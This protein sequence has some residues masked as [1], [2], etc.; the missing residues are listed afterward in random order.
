MTDRS[1]FRAFHALAMTAAATAGACAPKDSSD[2]R[3]DTSL[4]GARDTID[5]PEDIP[6]EAREWDELIVEIGPSPETDTGP[7]DVGP[8]APDF[9]LDTADPPEVTPAGLAAF[10]ASDAAL[11]A[12]CAC[13]SDQ[14]AGNI[15][16][17]QSRGL[18]GG[19]AL[20][21]C[22]AASLNRIGAET[23]PFLDCIVAA[24]DETAGCAASCE[25]D[26]CTSCAA[27]WA[28]LKND[29]TAR[30]PEG[31]VILADCGD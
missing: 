14:F 7:G 29:C 22:Q 6:Q 8:D 20:T 1:A 31:A 23:E 25:P 13:C 19:F 21:A 2:Q 9:S 18:S 28:A 26:P 3:A 16:L 15:A 12:W 11:A 30:H 24:L 10:E 4:P 5:G 17:C 27:G